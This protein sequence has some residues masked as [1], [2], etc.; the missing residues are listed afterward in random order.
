MTQT[1]PRSAR[2][3]E[4]SATRPEIVPMRVTGNHAFYVVKIPTTRSLATPK[5]VS[6]ATKLA[7]KPATATR[8]T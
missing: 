1:L 8:R 4:S 6:S 7:M 2:T 5:P 3:V